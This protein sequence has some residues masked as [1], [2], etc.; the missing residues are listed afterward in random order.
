MTEPNAQNV[1]TDRV[2]EKVAR[3]QYG[4]RPTRRHSDTETGRITGHLGTVT[5]TR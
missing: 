3:E 1:E 4:I 5:Q 2:G